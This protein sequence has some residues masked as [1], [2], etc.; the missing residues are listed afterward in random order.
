[1]GR[2]CR[3]CRPQRP[4]GAL[5]CRK[6]GR[7]GT[8]CNPYLPRT[9]PLI[10]LPMGR[11]C[12]PEQAQWTLI[13]PLETLNCRQIG[14]KP[15]TGLLDVRP[16]RFYFNFFLIQT[17][18][19]SILSWAIIGKIERAHLW[20]HFGLELISSCELSNSDKNVLQWM[21][22]SGLPRSLPN[23]DQC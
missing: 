7:I 2:F 6:V 22:G 15:S 14:T 4:L 21:F 8:I 17:P 23:V 19:E 9:C 10:T 3:F 12:R 5:Y 18:L 1:M 16:E 13:W 20:V 11:F